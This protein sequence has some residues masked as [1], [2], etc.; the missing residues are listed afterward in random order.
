M[1]YRHSRMTRI[2]L[3]TAAVADPVL[4]DLTST[5][6]GHGGLLYPFEISEDRLKRRV[7]HAWVAAPLKISVPC[8]SKYLRHQC[9]GSVKVCVIRSVYTI[10]DLEDPQW[11][12]GGLEIKRLCTRLCNSS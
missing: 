12:P 8:L 1:S 9:R 5:E 4:A 10:H 6:A 11:T 7:T 3:A 2:V